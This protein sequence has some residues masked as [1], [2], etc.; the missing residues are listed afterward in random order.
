[1]NTKETNEVIDVT[2]NVDE[3]SETTQQE[4]K[5]KYTFKSFI[6]DAFEF[7]LIFAITIAVYKL[8]FTYL[9]QRSEVSG[10][11]MEPTY[12]ESDQLISTRIGYTPKDN[13]VV[14]IDS[15]KLG[16]EIVKR[17]IATEG[18]TVDIDFIKG[19]VSVD[20]RQVDEQ[21]YSEDAKL[22]ADHFV[23][24]LTTNDMHA[25]DSYP[26]TVP[27]NCVF[28]LGDNRNVSLDSKHSQLGFVSYD[29]VKGKVLFKLPKIFSDISKKKN[30][31]IKG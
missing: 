6:K 24:T 14:I 10:K 13:D 7:I 8:T 26:V 1:M 3:S 15:Q 28:V 2:D 23:K 4:T 11:S 21:L 22:E 5:K 25:F 16:K 27:E 19:I 12:Y 17:V 31:S 30:D 29:E 9:L 20:G 18:Q